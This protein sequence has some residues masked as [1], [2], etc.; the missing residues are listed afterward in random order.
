MLH[1]YAPR[2]ATMSAR[3][4]IRLAWESVADYAVAPLQDLLR[5][6]TQARM[7]LPGRPVGNWHW[8]FR[9]EL[10]TNEA[11]DWLGNVTDV[12]GR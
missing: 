12:Y 9:A 11:L 10:L 8:R 6:G 2:P 3:E 4:M 1:R 5:L 7:N